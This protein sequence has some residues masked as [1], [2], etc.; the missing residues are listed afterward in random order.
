LSSTEPKTAG[1]KP[2]STQPYKRK[3]KVNVD[4]VQRI[5]VLQQTLVT[6]STSAAATTTGCRSPDK[7]WM[8]IYEGQPFQITFLAGLIK[9]CYGCGRNFTQ[10]HRNTPKDLILKKLDHRFY[11]NAVTGELTRT[12]NLQ[13]TLSP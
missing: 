11:I 4:E 8:D 13:N 5:D 10:Q 1:R 3:R 6:P 2:N 9:K 12:S 7:D